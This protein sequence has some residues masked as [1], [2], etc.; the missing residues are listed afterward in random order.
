MTQISSMTRVLSSVAAALTLALF[1]LPGQEALAQGNADLTVDVKKT[2]IISAPNGGSITIDPSNFSN[3]GVLTNNIT[4]TNAYKATIVS[5]QNHSI[6]VEATNNGNENVKDL[7]IVS[8][9]TTS[10]GELFGTSAGTFTVAGSQ[11]NG[12]KLIAAGTSNGAKTLAG[13]V[14]NIVGESFDAEYLLTVG[15]D[16]NPSQT[17]T[18][19][20]TYTISP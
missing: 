11:Y 4:I 12:Q 3:G 18:V 1:F 14:N 9:G 16:F 5:D 17:A 10:P 7:L 2:T 15:D 20:L 8:S 6:N 13:S 19:N